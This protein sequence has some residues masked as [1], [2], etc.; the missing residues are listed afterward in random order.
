MLVHCFGEI[1]RNR[2]HQELQRIHRKR[3]QKMKIPFYD[4]KK[5]NSE[6]GFELKQAI[7]DVVD[8]GSYILGEKVKSF[9]ENFRPIVNASM[10]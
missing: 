10:Q 7:E 4:L 8:S 3:I 6:I 9:E 1:S 5:L 2:L